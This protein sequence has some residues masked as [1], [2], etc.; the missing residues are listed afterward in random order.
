[1]LP[2]EHPKTWAAVGWLLVIGVVTGSLLPGPVVAQLAAWNDKVEHAAAYGLA[3]LG[4]ADRGA[5][6]AQVSDIES[7]YQMLCEG[8]GADIIMIEVHQD[9]KKFVEMLASE[10]ITVPVIACGIEMD[11]KAAA[12]AIRATGAMPDYFAQR[13]PLGR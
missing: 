9:I 2:L 13:L 8:H 6:V 7:A 12:A 4:R 1:M 11:A 10:R 3:V 5:K